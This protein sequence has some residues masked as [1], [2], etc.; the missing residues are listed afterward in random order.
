MASETGRRRGRAIPLRRSGCEVGSLED[1]RSRRGRRAGTRTHE[2]LEL[3]ESFVRQTVERLQVAAL[4]EHPGE[5]GRAREEALRDHLRSFLPPSL[6]VT[7]GFVIDALGQRSRQVDIIIHFADYHAVFMVSGIPRVPIEAV[8]AVIEVKSDA[9]S[10]QVLLDCYENL[11]S[12][13]S[14]DRSN[15]GQN[16][17]LIDHEPHALPAAMCDHLQFQVFAAV[18]AVRSSSPELW[19][20]TTSEWCSAQ[21][22]RVWPKFFCSVDG[23]I[24]TYLI[25]V[26]TYSGPNPDPTIGSALVAYK[27]EPETPLAW[28]TQ[29]ILNFIRVARRIDYSPRDY[30]SS[31]GDEPVPMLSAPLPPAVID[32]DQAGDASLV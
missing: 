27:P 11:R 21:P 13:K 18:L 17:Y 4:L 31:G 25:D 24:G 14:L 30:L 2:R 1:G 10:R 28:A 16:V 19:L 20:A 9:R 3:L 12:V 15:R 32:E 22:R 7:T 23:Y 5:V 8:I 29:E 6:G 26:P